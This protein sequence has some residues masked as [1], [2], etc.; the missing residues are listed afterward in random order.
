MN[1]PYSVGPLYPVKG[2]LL[3]EGY[4]QILIYQSVPGGLCLISPQYPT[5]EPF[6]FPADNGL[7]HSSKLCRGYLD[8][9]EE[10]VK[11][12]IK[13]FQNLFL[14]NLQHKHCCVHRVPY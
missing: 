2:I 8:R 10:A 4:K 7:K 3:K 11:Y 12:K 14:I 9:K 13:I 6:I 1:V 5:D